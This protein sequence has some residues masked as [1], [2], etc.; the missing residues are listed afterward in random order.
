MTAQ[1][2]VWVNPPESPVPRIAKQIRFAV[3]TPHGVSSDSWK[4]WVRGDDAYFACRDQLKEIKISLHASGVWRLALTESAVTKRPD[5]LAKGA[6]RLL[7]RWNPAP[8]AD[9]A[10]AFQLVVPPASLH[11]TSATRVGWPQSVVF[12]EPESAK[13]EFASVYAIVARTQ[14][15]VAIAPDTRAVVFGILP[16]AD[17]RSVQLLVVYEPA[18][19]TADLMARGIEEVIRSAEYHPNESHLIALFG[20]RADGVPWMSVVSFRAL[21]SDVVPRENDSSRQLPP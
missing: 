11:R 3:G 19:Q 6:D 18:D 20:A 8:G 13:G 21:L 7:Q 10:T 2:H 4:V 5:L 1:V 15:E 12:L 14:E 17:G 9:V 16:L